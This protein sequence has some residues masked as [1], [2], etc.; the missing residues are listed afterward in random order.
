MKSLPSFRSARASDGGFF[1][2]FK[3]ISERN[4]AM[5]APVIRSGAD[6]SFLYSSTAIG[7]L[8][9][10]DTGVIVEDLP[11]KQV[12]SV[13]CRGNPSEEEMAALARTVLD[14]E[15]KARGLTVRGPFLQLSYNSPM[16]PRDRC[17]YEMS[18][19]VVEK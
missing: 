17:F 16:V 9:T 12:L 2:L 5:T 1:K 18:L 11:T 8:G 15:V 6:M 4:I 14:A 19:E 3:H 13:G 10:T 7:S